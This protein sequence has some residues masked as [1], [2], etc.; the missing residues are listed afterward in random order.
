M[1]LLELVKEELRREDISAASTT[2]A[3]PSNTHFA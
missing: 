1:A 3:S 2:A